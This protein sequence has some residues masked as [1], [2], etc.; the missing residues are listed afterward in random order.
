MIAA[1]TSLLLANIRHPLEASLAAT[2]ANHVLKQSH[3]PDGD[4]SARW[5][6]QPVEAE[7]V[8]PGISGGRSRDKHSAYGAFDATP[9]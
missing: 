5:V 1:E 8:R 6:R 4:A 9:A 7:R 3:A 2:P